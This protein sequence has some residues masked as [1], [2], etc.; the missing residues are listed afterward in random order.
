MHLQQVLYNKH[1]VINFIY[2]QRKQC[3]YVK[4]YMKVVQLPILE[5]KIQHTVTIFEKKWLSL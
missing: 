1:Q 5:L 2:L 3:H 4:N